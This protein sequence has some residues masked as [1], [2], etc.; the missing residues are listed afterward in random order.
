MATLMSVDVSVCPH[1]FIPGIIQVT[2]WKLCLYH[3]LFVTFS[4]ICFYHLYCYRLWDE[5]K[6]FKSASL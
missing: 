2:I 4:L 3:F 6:I 5:I 1:L